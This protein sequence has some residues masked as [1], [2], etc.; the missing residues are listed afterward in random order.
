MRKG[1]RS[2][3]IRRTK[4]APMA[5]TWWQK[6]TES[7]TVPGT[8]SRLARASKGIMCRAPWGLGLKS[9]RQAQEMKK[10]VSNITAYMVIDIECQSNV[11]SSKNT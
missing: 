6:E 1:E 9:L 8:M 5:S 7:I 3:K 2:A 4:P 10:Q 11:P